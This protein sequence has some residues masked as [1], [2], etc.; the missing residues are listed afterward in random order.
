[1][2]GAD[3]NTALYWP[4]M[5]AER[6]IQPRHEAMVAENSSAANRAK[7]SKKMRSDVT[8]EDTTHN[9]THKC[10]EGDQL[11]IISGGAPLTDYE[12]LAIANKLEK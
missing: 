12:L 10:K 9:L 1:M 6:I 8:G 3:E 5:W 11:K 4:L 2:T 7:T